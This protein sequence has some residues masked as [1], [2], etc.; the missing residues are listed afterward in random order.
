[1]SFFLNLYIR[2]Q[3]RAGTLTCSYDVRVCWFNKDISLSLQFKLILTY[4]TDAT[5][6]CMHFPSFQGYCNTHPLFSQCIYTKQNLHLIVNAFTQLIA[7]FS[8]LEHFSTYRIDIMLCIF[9][10]TGD[11][12]NFH[13]TVTCTVI[14][15]F[16]SVCS[17]V[18][19]V[20]VCEVQYAAIDAL[21]I[22]LFDPINNQLRV[23][24]CFTS[25]DKR[26]TFNYSI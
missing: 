20:D 6:W 5:K 2:K 14:L 22:V 8:H 19:S 24:R 23:T 16:T 26:I 17:T 18:I 7:Y 4:K 25:H 13:P 1:M 11:V 15:H 3:Y 9:V 12:D 21:I 10:L